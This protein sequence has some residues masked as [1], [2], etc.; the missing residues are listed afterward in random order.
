MPMSDNMKQHIVQE[1]PN[2]TIIDARKN[3][4]PG[5]KGPRHQEGGGTGWSPLDRTWITIDRARKLQK[6]YAGMP[7]KEVYGKGVLS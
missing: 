5:P 1:A 3:R 6:L 7:M 2:T 4:V